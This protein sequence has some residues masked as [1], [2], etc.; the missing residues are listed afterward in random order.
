M[1]DIT[2]AAM[3]RWRIKLITRRAAR[4]LAI[5]FVIM[6][7]GGVWGFM[8]LLR[9]PGASFTGPLPPATVTQQA[10]ADELKTIVEKLAVE[11]G[12][13]P[14]MS[15]QATKETVTYL[16]EALATAG[17]AVQ[18]QTFTTS[19]G[20]TLKNLEAVLPGREAP[21]EIV[22]IG[23]HYDTIAAVSGADDNAS[24]VA[25]VL[26]L[27]RS[28]AAAQRRRTI[29]FVFFASEEPPYFRTDD[30]GSR[31]YAKASKQRGEQIKAMI[32]LDAIG[33]FSSAPG[34][35]RYPFPFSWFYPDRGDFILFASGIASRDLL[36]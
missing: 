4:R 32:A 25:A 6:A 12:A 35:Q 9:M 8:E 20:H 13:R 2:S 30:M 14:V 21:Q 24:G 26:S 34:S 11:I 3:P 29:R 23:A 17:Y 31:V 19:D 27:A 36:K 15:P 5:V 7:I 33:T 18:R 10:R 16:Q 1:T 28:F 22:I